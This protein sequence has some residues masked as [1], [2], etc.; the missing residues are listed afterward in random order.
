MQ[1]AAVSIYTK[2]DDNLKIIYYY[3]LLSQYLVSDYLSEITMSLL[4]AVRNKRPELGF[5]PDF[6]ESTAPHLAE[7]KRRGIRI[8]TNGGE[9]YAGRY[10]SYGRKKIIKDVSAQTILS[11]KNEKYF[12]QA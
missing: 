1:L 9:D 5:T 2:S 6:L 7:I 12:P 4:A 11:F 10:I 8:V 3:I